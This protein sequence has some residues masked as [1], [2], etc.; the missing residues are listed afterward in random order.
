MMKTKHNLIFVILLMFFVLMMITPD[1]LIPATISGIK[2][3]GLK[4]APGLI[5]GMIFIECFNYYIPADY[6]YGT[7]LVI[8][9]SLLCGFPAG[10]LNCIKYQKN[11]NNKEWFTYIMPYCNISS[12]GFVINYIYYN[13]LSEHFNIFCYLLCVYLPTILLIIYEYVRN[14]TAA[15]CIRDSKRYIQSAEYMDFFTILNNSIDKMLTSV[16]KLGGY[17]IIF[18][19]LCAYIQ[20]FSHMV[21]MPYI[22]WIVCGF[23]EITNGIYFASDIKS[24]LIKILLISAINAFGGLS[25]LM[26]TYSVI[27]DNVGVCID[28]KKYIFQK[29]KL[30]ICTILVTYLVITISSE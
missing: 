6:T 25:T 26:Q 4:V 20:Y 12:P 11:Y 22:N 13:Y 29:I 2:L 27:K 17:I 1:I 8:L 14:R 5:M 7:F 21:S 24:H 10:A 18:S 30:T 3:W 16:L 28:I 19:C 15:K 23:M 9:S